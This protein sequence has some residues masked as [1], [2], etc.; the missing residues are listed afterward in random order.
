MLWMLVSRIGVGSIAAALSDISMLGFL[1]AACIY[2]V[3]QFVSSVR[4]RLLLAD[5]FPLGRLYSLYL[6]GSFFNIFLPGIV[7]G[8]AVKVYYLYR[9]TGKGAH[10]LGSVFMDRYAGFCALILLGLIA[11]PFGFRHFGGTWL[12]W[13]IPLMAVI[14]IAASMVIFGMRFGGRRL[15]ALSAFYDYFHQY[16]GRRDVFVKAL[17]LSAAV[18][19]MAML[20]V[21]VISKG[22]GH[23]VPFIAYM[24][25]LPIITAIS[26][27]PISI[28]GLGMREAAFVILLASVGVSEESAMAL[29]FAWFLSMALASLAGLLEYLRGRRSGEKVRGVSI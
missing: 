1:G 17:A 11:Y 22:Q 13:L 6:M 9:D 18:Q 19:F 7:G 29:S 16:I 2:L 14:F 20:A 24:V 25:F 3:A 10:A 5:P 23:D 26:S 15:A 27:I 21:F 8:D 12:K 28:S 4:W